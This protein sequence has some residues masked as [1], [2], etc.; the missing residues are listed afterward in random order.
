MLSKQARI[1]AVAPRLKELVHAHKEATYKGGPEAFH[2]EI[3]TVIENSDL[4]TTE[5][6]LCTCVA[7]HPDNRARAM[8]IAIDAQDLLLKFTDNG[9]NPR[10]WDALA[11]T[12]PPG[13]AEGD[14]WR[15]KNVELVQDSDGL[16]APIQAD[17]IE[18][19]TGRG[20]HG[21]AACRMAVLGARSVHPALADSNGMVSKAK[22]LEL[23]PSWRDPLENGLVYKILPGELELAVPGLLACLSLLGNA[24]NDVY[25]QPTA[26]QLCARIHSLITGHPGKDDAWIVKQASVGYGGSSYEA[27]AT[28]LMEFVKAWSGGK[29]GQNLK[30]LESYERSIEVK[31]HLAHADLQCLASADLLHAHTYI[32]A[33]RA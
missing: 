9:Y 22:L 10:M 11:L 6:K 17:S 7:V 2:S 3:M 28:Q 32:Q 14:S 4:M 1:E 16:L 25:R 20:S 21:T 26:L 13:S 12:I 8:L 23:Q 19:V 31:R 27:K 5:K 15:Q 30:D 24:S 33:T 18:I 29:A